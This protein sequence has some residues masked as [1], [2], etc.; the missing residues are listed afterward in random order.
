MRYEIVCN[1][2]VVAQFMAESDAEI[3][4]DCLEEAYDDCEFTLREIR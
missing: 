1:G 4:L 2:T 3:C